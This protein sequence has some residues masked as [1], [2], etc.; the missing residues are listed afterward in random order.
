MID[1]RLEEHGSDY[2]TDHDVDALIEEFEGNTR[3]AIRAL[4]HDL[5]VL[6]RDASAT[7]SRGFVRGRFWEIR[8]VGDER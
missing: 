2:P 8:R 4:L 7:T 6:A 3:E 5:A 1:R